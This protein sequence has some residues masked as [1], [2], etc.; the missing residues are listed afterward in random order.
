M[1]VPA[2]SSKY[3][4]NLDGLRTVAFLLVFMSHAIGTS[5]FMKQDGAWFVRS[6]F[7]HYNF[8]AMGVNLFFVL[9]GFLITYLLLM[10]LDKHGR[11]SLKK[12]YAR[13][14]LRIWPLYMVV[15]IAAIALSLAAQ[16]NF[17]GV[18]EEHIMYGRNLL[19]YALFAGNINLV[20]LHG[21]TT[22]LLGPL[23]SV[24]VEEQFYL[25][26]PIIVAYIRAAMLGWVLSVV[27]VTSLIFR[28]LNSENE[29]SILYHSLSVAGDIG[30]GC[31]I[32]WMYVNRPTRLDVLI[33]SSKTRILIGYVL[34][35]ATLILFGLKRQFG[36]FE[37]PVIVVEAF[38]TSV[39]FG[40]I[41]LEQ[42]FSQFSLFKMGHFGLFT[43]L[44]KYTYSLY[45]LHLPAILV[46]HAL[47]SKI[48]VAD[49]INGWLLLIVELTMAL[50]LSIFLSLISYRYIETP[51]LKIKERF[52]DLKGVA[53]LKAVK[54]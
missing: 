4:E 19:F 52:S 21:R 37:G 42:N 45:C 41:I 50:A 30:I 12:F 8:G 43:R 33:N 13:R 10:E 17:M 46:V 51:F 29:V 48:W 6:V 15:F 26:W 25:I 18:G 20:M 40:F 49:N 32:A 22:P 34:G 38:M 27:L 53:D 23:W 36:F 7:A 47:S 28:A 16:H 54:N 31:L 39:F 1:I 44:G 5:M 35:I 3:F 11:I 24:S 14:L 9:S 2:P